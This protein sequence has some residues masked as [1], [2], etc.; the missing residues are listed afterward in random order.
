MSSNSRLR[1]LEVVIAAISGCL[2]KDRAHHD[3]AVA[4]DFSQHN[5]S[6]SLA[7]T[8]MNSFILYSIALH[9]R[10]YACIVE[11]GVEV[12]IVNVDLSFVR[13]LVPISNR[14]LTLSSTYTPT[15]MSKSCSKSKSPPVDI[16]PK[17]EEDIKLEESLFPP[18][19]TKSSKPE[20]SP[21]LKRESSESAVNVKPKPTGPQLIGDLPRAEAAAH[22]T[23]VEIPDNHYQYGTLGRSREEGES[24]TCDCQY[25]HGWFDTILSSIVV[26]SKF[27][28]RRCR[29]PIGCLWA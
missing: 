1:F 12:V 10:I 19:D 26:D 8:Y 15:T 22:A 3:I 9:R 14:G 2:L 13:G 4:R 20:P 11:F 5:R 23:F 7:Q 29:R 28:L 27:L 25:E 6:V 21:P 18:V 16:K 17:L 24:M